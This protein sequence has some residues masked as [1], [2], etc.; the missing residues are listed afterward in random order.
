MSRPWLGHGGGARLCGLRSAPR[1]CRPIAPPGFRKLA[2]LLA[3]WLLIHGS[4]LCADSP[5]GRALLSAVPCERSPDID[6]SLTDSAWLGAAPVRIL[7]KG[8]DHGYF[9]LCY[10]EQHLYLAASLSE[11]NPYTVFAPSAQRDADLRDHES[12]ELHLRTTE[13]GGDTYRLAVSAANV[14]FDSRYR[15]G[16]ED[17]AWNGRWRSAARAGHVCWQAEIA[18][19]FTDLEVA[20]P[21]DGTLLEMN[22]VRNRVKDDSIRRFSWNPKADSD[23]ARPGSLGLLRFSSTAH[24]A[25]VAELDEFFTGKRNGP[26]LWIRGTARGRVRVKAGTPEE[27]VIVKEVEL[28]R[29]RTDL[30]IDLRLRDQILSIEIEDD[31]EQLLFATGHFPLEAPEG[32]ADVRH[33]L[34]ALRHPPEFSS[35]LAAKIAEMEKSGRFSAAAGEMWDGFRRGFIRE[36]VAYQFMLSGPAGADGE[37]AYGLATASSMTKVLPKEP[38]LFAGEYGNRIE[39]SAAGNE[40]ESHQVVVLSPEK[41]LQDVQLAWSNLVSPE[42]DVIEASQIAAATMGYVQTQETPPY[43]VPYTGWYPDPIL[44]YLDRFPI[45]QGDLHAV[46]YSVTVPEGAAPG[47]Y[48]G[49]LTIRPANAIEA[50][51]PIRLQ[52]WDFSL[53]DDASLRTAIN[54]SVINLHHKE[55]TPERIQELR[56]LYEAFLV[57]HRTA[58]GGIYQLHET[59]P[60]ETTLERWAR[61]GSSTFNVVSIRKW[62]MTVDD[63]G[64]FVDLKPEFRPIFQERIG[65]ALAVARRLGIEDRAYLYLYDERIEEDFEGIERVASWLKEEFPNL[66]LMTTSSEPTYGEMLPSVDWFVPLSMYYDPPRAREARRRGKEVWWYVYAAPHEP[67]ASMLIEKPGIDPRI[68]LGFMS[69]AYDVDGFLYYSMSRMTNNSQTLRGGPYT[70]WNTRSWGK[71]NGDGHVLYPHPTGPVTSIRMENWLDG[72][73]DYEYLAM[74]ERRIEQLRK[75]GQASRADRI[76]EQFQPYTAPNNELVVSR[77]E[78]ARQPALLEEARTN[79]AEL[80]VLTN[81]RGH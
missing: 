45:A 5:G 76:L 53:P 27:P 79:L 18:I 47:W 75:N 58:C 40:T 77:T 30:D 61:L 21:T 67:Y 25:Y 74:L 46:W 66:P 33:R 39:L 13:G 41:D 51:V 14:Q 60:D 20:A 55:E 11:R 17:T 12:I 57:A 43:P 52:V 28:A 29:Y 1:S 49:T 36:L 69:F 64:R 19:P 4:G 15:D 78:Y 68:L 65:E 6:G 8:Q 3:T 50:V 31:S 59:P 10:D 80:I 2:F 22:L 34:A 26:S 54:I 48:E 37:P 7:A 70:T 16:C 73:E 23:G 72:L 56:K 32:L 71:Y 62:H 24:Y 35:A 63:K 42:G 9:S 44:R 38:Q 81:D